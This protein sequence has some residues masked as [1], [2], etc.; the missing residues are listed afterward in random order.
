MSSD[1]KELLKRAIVVDGLCHTLIGDP[2]PAPPGKEIVDLILEGGV[3]VIN[4]TVILDYYKNDFTT[5]VK[6]LYRFFVLEEAIPEKLLIVR[7]YADIVRAKNEGKLGV[8]LSM[9]G[10]DAIEHDIRY[11]TIL[12]KLG[13]RIIQIT[14]NQR[15]NI[16][17]GAYEPNDTGLTRFGQQAILEMNRLGILIDLSH[18]GYRTSLDAIE[19]SQDPVVFSH[20]S[21]KAL[22]PHPRNITDEQI[23][24]VAAKGG[25]VGLCPHS[26]MTVMK[27]RSSWPTVDDFIDHIAYVMDLVGEDFVGIGTDRWMRP[28]LAYKMLRVEFE[29]TL[30]GFFG[31]FTGEQKHVDGF[32]FYDHWSNLVEHLQK[33]RFTDAQICKILGGNFVRVFKAVFDKH[34]A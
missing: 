28:T 18:V 14:Y 22:N 9:Q 25:V 10:A 4:A 13:V 12:H 32:N 3:N 19:F 17:C 31:Q 20:S 7:N 1:S 26:V 15:N 33:R 8:I 21:V 29:R 23:K 5:Y 2:P 24:A 11:I 27:G 30:P 34:G 16:G 6:E